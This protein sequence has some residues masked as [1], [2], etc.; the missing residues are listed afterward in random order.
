MSSLSQYWYDEA[1]NHIEK[2]MALAW[3]HEKLTL[4]YGWQYKEFLELFCFIEPCMAAIVKKN[5]HIKFLYAIF[6]NYF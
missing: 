3:F 4:H 2:I 1:P 6:I 5:W